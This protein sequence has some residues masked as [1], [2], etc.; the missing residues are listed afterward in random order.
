GL[1]DAIVSN[2][3]GSALSAAAR[4]LVLV[5]PSILLAPVS[6]LV[7]TGATVAFSV[8][9]RATPPITY[10]WRFNSLTLPGETAPSL[11]R[12][13]ITLADDGVY[14]VLISSPAGMLRASSTLGVKVTPVIVAPPLS[15]PPAPG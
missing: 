4:L 13:N 6:Q 14:D 15:Q 9:A 1:Y 8:V 7:S 5:P 2:P 3:G 12:T 11:V 10:Q